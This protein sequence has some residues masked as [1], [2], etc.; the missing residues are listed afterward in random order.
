MFDVP[1]CYV[2][3]SD[4]DVVKMNKNPLSLN[5]VSANSNVRIICN[6]RFFFSFL[7][8]CILHYR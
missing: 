2:Y 7:A 5:P 4:N 3:R 6:Q 8:E 1:T